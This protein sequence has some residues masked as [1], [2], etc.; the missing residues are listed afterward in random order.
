MEYLVEARSEKTRKFIE[1]LMPSIIKQLGLT[2]SRKAVVIR[3]ARGECDGMGMTVPV[4]ILDS[5]VIVISPMKLKEIGLTLSHEMVHV[6]QMAKGKLKTAKNGSAVWCG[7]QYSK[8]TKYL[9]MPWEVDAFS[10][11]EIIFRRAIE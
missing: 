11:Q 10:K 9:N 2:Q 6:A 7:K 1:C 3:V 8:R 5:Y 4:D